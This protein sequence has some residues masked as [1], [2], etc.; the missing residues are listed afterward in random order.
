[1]GA[2]WQHSRPPLLWVV[3]SEGW[4]GSGNGGGKV[5]SRRLDH[6]III[7]LRGGLLRG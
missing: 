6:R 3:R 7:E 4:I 1:M 5:Q 2:H